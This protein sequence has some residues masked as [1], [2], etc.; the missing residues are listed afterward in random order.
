[1]KLGPLAVEFAWDHLNSPDRYIRYA[2]RVAIEW[3]DLA[4]WRDKALA[5][6]RPTALINA[7]VALCRSANPAD[8]GKEGQPPAY[9]STLRRSPP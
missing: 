8:E 5:E 4:L 7:M 6:K 2:A 9:A 1:M 3:Q